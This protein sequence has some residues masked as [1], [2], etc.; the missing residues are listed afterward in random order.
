MNV[1]VTRSSKHV[2]PHLAR[3]C[4]VSTFFED[5][6]RNKVVISELNISLCLVNVESDVLWSNNTLIG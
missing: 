4:L 3:F 2:L 1:Q 6:I 5:G